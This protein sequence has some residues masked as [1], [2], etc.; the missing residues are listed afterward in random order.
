[1]TISNP[2][3]RYHYMDNLRA[4]LWSFYDLALFHVVQYW[5]KKYRQKV[6]SRRII[7]I[8]LTHWGTEQCRHSN[9]YP[10][11]CWSHRH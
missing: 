6:S 9:A 2:T 3:P 10:S 7:G 4:L 8:P 1:M 5:M 11:L